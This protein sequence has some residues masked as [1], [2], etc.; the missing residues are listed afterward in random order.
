[1]LMVSLEGCLRDAGHVTILRYDYLRAVTARSSER[2]L[3]VHPS[4]HTS[5][6]T[7]L[8]LP[9]MYNTHHKAIPQPNF[10]ALGLLATVVS[11]TE[12]D[13]AVQV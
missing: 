4:Q 8:K 5:G 2:A 9:E 3:Q 13:E 7:G 1:M 10:I 12:I 6:L 11:L